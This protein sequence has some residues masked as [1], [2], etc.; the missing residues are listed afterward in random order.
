M[1]PVGGQG[2]NIALRD[3]LVAANHLVPALESGADPD[4]LDAAAQAFQK[5]R[6]PEVE[7][8]QRMQRI[9]PR[10]I[11]ER[12]WWNRWV[13]AVLPTLARLQ[14]LF[15]RG[16]PAIERFMFGVTDVELRV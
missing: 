9:P 4:V 10:L 14:L 1:S 13:L 2:I 12:S 8:L 5:E 16:G 6:Y 11:F 15:P 3:A 7:L